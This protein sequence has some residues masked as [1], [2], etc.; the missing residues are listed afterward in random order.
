MR[1]L[2][3]ISVSSAVLALLAIGLTA[4]P[5]AADTAATISIDGDGRSVTHLAGSGQV[6]ELQVTPMGAGTGVRRVAFNDEVPIRVGEQH[7]VQPDPNDAT[8]V[9]CE[10]PTADASSGEIRILLGDGDDEFFTDAPG[11]S[12]VH[13]GSGN[14]QLHAHSAHTV[15]GGQDDDMLMGGVVMHGGDGMDHL[16]GDDRGQVLTGGRGADHIEAHGGADTVHAGFGDDHVT[17]GSG[18]DFLS[19]GFG[20]DTVHG[21]SGNDTLLGGPGKDVLS[22]GPDTDTI[23]W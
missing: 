12:V 18:D 16:M 7:C 22:G 8:R 3:V 5:A 13:G 2:R 9:V 20:D 4:A 11:V 19:G 1:E 23:L 17:G 21:D 10:L 14:D 15:I 6:N